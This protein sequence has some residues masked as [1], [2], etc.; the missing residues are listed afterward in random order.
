MNKV[1]VGNLE[2]GTSGDDLRRRFAPY[3]EI[4]DVLV[5]T[6]RG[7]GFV[8]FE[9]EKD[10]RFAVASCASSSLRVEMA[11]QPKPP[12]PREDPGAVRG[13]GGKGGQRMPNRKALRRLW[14]K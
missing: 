6:D 5:I 1:Y 12:H 9:Q 4:E 8:I 14:H 11:D 3:G 10:A 13:D 2:P 7:F